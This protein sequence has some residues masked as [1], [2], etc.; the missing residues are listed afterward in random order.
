MQMSD[1]AFS[2]CLKCFIMKI[3]LNVFRSYICKNEIFGWVCVVCDS[4]AESWGRE[5]GLLEEPV[6]PQAVQG[7]EVSP[8]QSIAGLC[9]DPLPGLLGVQKTGFPAEWSLAAGPLSMVLFCPGGIQKQAQLC[10]VGRCG[11]V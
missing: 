6:I 3:Y 11:S 1:K 8:R 2:V 10:F 7:R 4:G 9:R 5:S